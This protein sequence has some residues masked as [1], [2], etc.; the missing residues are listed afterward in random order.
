[1]QSTLSDTDIERLQGT[2][3][4]MNEANASGERRYFRASDLYEPR[5]V[6]RQLGLPVIDWGTTSWRGFSEQG[7]QL[8]LESSYKELTS[9][10]S[11]QNFFTNWVFVARLH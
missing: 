9:L 6:F 10:E 4:F 7:Q 8:R 1:M 5:H 3:A 2:F 11:K